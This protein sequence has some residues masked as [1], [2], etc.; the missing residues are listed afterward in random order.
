MKLGAA[1][2]AS[3]AG[4]TCVRL[5]PHAA[6]GG[7]A[8]AVITAAA[9]PRLLLDTVDANIILSGES[10]VCVCFVKVLDELSGKG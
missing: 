2:V 4:G 9:R 10:I 3:T 8:A 5:K 7:R 1:W 6:V